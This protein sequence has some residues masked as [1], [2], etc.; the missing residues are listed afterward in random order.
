MSK[1]IAVCE[2]KYVEFQCKAQ[3]S[4][5]NRYGCGIQMVR[6]IQMTRFC[7]KFFDNANGNVK[8]N[9]VCQSLKLVCQVVRG[10]HIFKGLA[11]RK[12]GIC[13]RGERVTRNFK[14]FEKYFPPI[15][16]DVEVVGTGIP[17]LDGQPHCPHLCARL[18][19]LN[20]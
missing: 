12:S 19:A 6:G 5:F 16:T 17:F 8:M 13:D 15:G 3:R 11:K 9:F 1:S 4:F 10:K 2:S 14:I 20:L 18:C 7:A